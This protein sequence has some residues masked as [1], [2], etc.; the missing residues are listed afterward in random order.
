M[1]VINWQLKHFKNNEIERIKKEEKKK[2]EA[3]LAKFWNDVERACQ[4]K[5]E[6][7]LSR[8]KMSL[9]RIQKHQEVIFKNHLLGGSFLQLLVD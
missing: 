6:A 8:E 9:E 3:E 4:A 2:S 7:L 1:F 5:S